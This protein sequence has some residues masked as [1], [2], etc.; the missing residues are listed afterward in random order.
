MRKYTRERRLRICGISSHRMVETFVIYATS[1]RSFIPTTLI[2]DV[3]EG[4][5]VDRCHGVEDV[6]H[7]AVLAV[8][9]RLDAEGDSVVV[10]VHHLAL[11]VDAVTHLLVRQVLRHLLQLRKHVSDV[12]RGVDA[13][14]HVIA[15]LLLLELDALIAEA[16]LAL[17]VRELLFQRLLVCGQ[18]VLH[19]S[20]HRA[21][22]AGLP[23]QRHECLARAHG[24]AAGDGLL[25]ILEQFHRALQDGQV[26]ARSQLVALHQTA[27]QAVEVLLLTVHESG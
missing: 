19:F 25:Q 5:P 24:G 8:D 12:S 26:T 21:W 17:G 23:H 14:A 22:D 7:L 10:V 27:K 11:Q 3:L 1:E 4:G 13:V 9:Q 2:A 20:I 18:G 16:V 15:V 6:L